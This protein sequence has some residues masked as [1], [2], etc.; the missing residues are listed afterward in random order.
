MEGT[1]RFDLKGQEVE[2]ITPQH[3]AYAQERLHLI[4]KA[5]EAKKG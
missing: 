5:I 2:E 1:H 3:K 4:T